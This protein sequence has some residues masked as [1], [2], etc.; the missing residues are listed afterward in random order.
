[1]KITLKTSLCLF[2]IGFGENAEK[3]LVLETSIKHGN[4]VTNP[5]KYMID[6]IKGCQEP[7]G[8]QSIIV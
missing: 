1:M 4:T 5:S 7:F 8:K 6:T 3:S 2:V